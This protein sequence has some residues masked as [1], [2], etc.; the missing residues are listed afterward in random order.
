MSQPGTY[1]CFDR[2]YKLKNSGAP[3]EEYNVSPLFAGEFSYYLGLKKTWLAFGKF[4]NCL[5]RPFYFLP[6][7]PHGISGLFRM[8]CSTSY[9]WLLTF[10]SVDLPLPVVLIL[11]FA[12][13]T[14]VHMAPTGECTH[15]VTIQ[16]D[17]VTIYFLRHTKLADTFSPT[18]CGWETVSRSIWQ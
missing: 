4:S 5:S 17:L 15:C 3:D 7:P 11:T 6:P 14:P 8:L 9:S 1:Y 2:Y 10:T 18:P 12:E 13:T 16:C